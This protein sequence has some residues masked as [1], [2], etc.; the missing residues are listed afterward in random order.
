[1][2]RRAVITGTSVIQLP[3]ISYFKKKTYLITAVFS[4]TLGV[5][6]FQKTCRLETERHYGTHYGTFIP[7]R[8]FQQFQSR[9]V[10]TLWR[11]YLG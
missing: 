3:L 9:I 1:M 11:N 6:M 4:N 10:S 2:V 8:F 5:I 7:V